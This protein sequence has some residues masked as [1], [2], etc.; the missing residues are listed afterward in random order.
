MSHP[1]KLNRFLTQLHEMRAR[2]DEHAEQIREESSHGID[3]ETSE[4]FSNAPVDLADRACLQTEVAVNIGLA[5]NEAH[6]RTEIDDAL[7]RIANGTF[8]ICAECGAVIA[9]NRL[10]AVPYARF[11]IRCERRFER[12]AE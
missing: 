12:A 5:E 11:C 6:L 3:G 7:E 8:G 10:R 9:A 2:L 1:I 4:G